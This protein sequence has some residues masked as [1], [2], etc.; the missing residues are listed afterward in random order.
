[1]W[2]THQRTVC[3]SNTEVRPIK[4]YDIWK[5]TRRDRNLVREYSCA[6]LAASS[7]SERSLCKILKVISSSIP[8]NHVHPL[9]TQDK[10]MYV[11]IFL[12]PPRCFT[13]DTL[14]VFSCNSKKK[15][16]KIN[17]TK[18]LTWKVCK[19][20]KKKMLCGCRINYYFYGFNVY[21]YFNLVHFIVLYSFNYSINIFL[22]HILH[23]IF[24]FNHQF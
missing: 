9:Q 20:K 21:T 17:H 3:L 13:P 5:Q 15:K 16:L 14:S 4:Q 19:L 10:N 11:F 22:N 8:Q 18:H 23:S 2:F 7:G 24:Y 6:T 1:M 12:A